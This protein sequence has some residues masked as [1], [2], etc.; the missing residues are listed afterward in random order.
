M[1]PV[2]LGNTQYDTGGEYSPQ[3]DLLTECRFLRLA[4][5]DQSL[6]SSRRDG[7]EAL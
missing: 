4:S 3:G 7:A 1:S 6:D 2:R 5:G